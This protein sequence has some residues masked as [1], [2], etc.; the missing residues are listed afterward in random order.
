M[1]QNE[2]NGERE[3][4]RTGE[5]QHDETQY[6]E[7]QPDKAQHGEVRGLS[8]GGSLPESVPA[9][10]TAGEVA[11]DETESELGACL[12]YTSRCV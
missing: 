12:L 11:S 6:G 2:Q 8:G 1:T 7:I 10:D 3:N 9:R 5:T 4:P